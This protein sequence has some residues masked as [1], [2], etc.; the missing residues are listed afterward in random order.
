VVLFGKSHLAPNEKSGHVLRFLIHQ[1]NLSFIP[2]MQLVNFE[3]G[4]IGKRRM[5][6]PENMGNQNPYNIHQATPK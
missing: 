1:S 2:E 4:K 3:K 6:N 5:A